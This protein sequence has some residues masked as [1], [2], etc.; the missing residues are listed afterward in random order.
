M[1]PTMPAS[2]TTVD[3]AQLDRETPDCGDAPRCERA[4]AHGCSAFTQASMPLTIGSLSESGVI[5]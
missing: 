4:A 1:Q 2:R 3:P 5:G